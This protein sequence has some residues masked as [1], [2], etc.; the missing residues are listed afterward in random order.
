MNKAYEV[1]EYIFSTY[2]FTL[3]PV[4]FYPCPSEVICD[5]VLSP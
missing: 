1:V 4:D 2:L 5:L 3:I